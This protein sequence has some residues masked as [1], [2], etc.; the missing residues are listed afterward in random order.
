MTYASISIEVNAIINGQVLA[1]AA[2]TFQSN[3]AVT[4]PRLKA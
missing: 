2:V 4:N 3:N 1:G